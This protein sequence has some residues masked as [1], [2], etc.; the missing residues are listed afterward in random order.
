MH[1]LMSSILHVEQLCKW[2][3]CI[4]IFTSKVAISFFEW[5]LAN[6]TRKREK[7]GCPKIKIAYP[8][9]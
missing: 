3:L 9:L 6:H 1:M 5:I 8:G 4:A 2:C 7:I